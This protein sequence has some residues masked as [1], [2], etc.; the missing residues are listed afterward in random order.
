MDEVPVEYLLGTSRS[1]LKDLRLRKLTLSANLRKQLIASA[2]EWVERSAEALLIQWLDEHGEEL[3]VAL[4]A[5]SASV[6]FAGGGNGEAT[7]P[8]PPLMRAACAGR[9]DFW[10]SQRRH[11]RR[12]RKIA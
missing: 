9:Y 2:Q 8:K 3:L 7:E 11:A 6:E 12:H 10:R 1:A 5:D 4:T